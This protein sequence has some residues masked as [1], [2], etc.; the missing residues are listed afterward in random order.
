[1]PSSP[2]ISTPELQRLQI[3]A[4]AMMAGVVPFTL[5][6]IFIAGSMPPNAG[7]PMISLVAGGMA[8]LALVGINMIPL[9]PLPTEAGTRSFSQKVFLQTI[10][11]FALCEGGCMI[12]LVAFILEQRWWS[13][14]FPA[15]LLTSMAALF[16][17]RGRI[18][19]Q[20]EREQAA[21]ID[22]FTGEPRS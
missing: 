6:A 4:I 18:E 22:E 12:N 7:T 8:A 17:T 15:L 1:M 20:W 14:G 13:L 5:V 11:R 10:L 21:A 19:S 16:P 3:I 9:L 2:P